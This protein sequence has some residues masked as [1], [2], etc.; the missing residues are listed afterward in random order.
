MKATKRMLE[1]VM[2]R[3]LKDDLRE[4]SGG[5]PKREVV[6]ENIDKVCPQTLPTA[7][8]C[9]AERVFADSRGTSRE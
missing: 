6:Q 1:D 7:P 8:D 5:F 4:V 3:R 9:L 2:V